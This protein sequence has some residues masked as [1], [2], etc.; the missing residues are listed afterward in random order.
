M[1]PAF[2]NFS[3]PS[4]LSR[5][6]LRFETQRRRPPSSPTKAKAPRQTLQS[7]VPQTQPP[8]TPQPSKRHS[9]DFV[10]DSVLKVY[11]THCEPNYELPWA[12]TAQRHS[13]ASAFIISGRRILTNAHAV[14]HHTSVRLKK[15][16]SDVRYHAKVVA[17]GNECDIA[18]LQVDDEEFWDEF[19]E[20]H[21]SK[22]LLYPGPLPELQD[23]VRVIGYPS[24]G[25]QISV[26]AGV[27][28]RVEMQHYVH[29]QDELLAVQIDAAINP[30]NSGGP[31][32]NEQLQVIG[33]AFQ[34]VDPSQADSVGYFIPFSVV[35]HFLDDIARHRRYTGFPFC[36]FHWQRMENPY[37][38]R[39][40]GMKSGSSGILVKWVA[41][42]VDAARV[43]KKGDV[44][45]HIDG[46]SISNAGTIPFRNGERIDLDYMVTNKFSDDPI[47]VTFQ[48]DGKQHEESYRLSRMQ[49]HCLVPIHDARHMERRQPEYL[50]CGGLVFQSLSEPFLRAV[51]GQ[52]WLF[53]APVQLV[54]LY[55][56]G[57]KTRAGRAE[58]VLLTQILSASCTSGYETEN[59]PDIKVLRKLNSTS[60]NSLK[61]LAS[62]LD[63]CPRDVRDLRFELDKNDI[64][65]IDRR[66]ACEEEREVLATYC[67]P[68]ARSLGS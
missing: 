16:Y 50:I 12:M 39:A 62:L 66:I 43:L 1:A 4:F 54:E 26:T 48:R 21:D 51:Y 38:R 45:T 29:G 57:T 10:L 6:R 32:I 67:I 63:D 15:R 59:E 20:C 64:I 30:G 33:I 53:E 31:V 18:L 14:E 36:G 9:I 25:N 46:I 56:N 23:A 22:S 41:E 68:A 61:H 35:N 42:T 7:P 40:Y 3:R 8:P 65:I 24:P 27:C 52:N 60:V 58:V 49:E 13:T 5:P 34:S 17:I 28:S 11:C 2:M 37:L 47:T 19:E 44:V 55:Y